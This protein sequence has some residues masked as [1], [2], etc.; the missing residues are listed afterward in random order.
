MGLLAIVG[1]GMM[2]M[3][4]NMTLSVAYVTAQQD[5]IALRSEIFSRVSNDTSCKSALQ[6]DP[7]FVFKPA[8]A[9]TPTGQA[10]TLKLGGGSLINAGAKVG[11][12]E[13]TE[14]SLVN[15][16]PFGSTGGYY[17]ADIWLRAK[18]VNKVMGPSDFPGK[19]VASVNL[20]VPA[21]GVI[22]SCGSSATLASQLWSCSDS[23]GFF[24]MFTGL[25]AKDCCVNP[26]P[27]FGR[28]STSGTSG[29]TL[30]KAG[31]T[32][33][34]GFLGGKCSTS[35]ERLCIAN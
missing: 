6:G 34:C 35:Y 22:Q 3:V 15:A 20:T 5:M 1:A 4:Q 25:T 14:L 21:S 27:F 31:G 16:E 11:S 18:A 32:Q 33:V 30:F 24:S 12:I 28:A 2:T 17:R 9:K 23:G 8:L 26:N 29:R 10:I 7:N 19:V 13:L